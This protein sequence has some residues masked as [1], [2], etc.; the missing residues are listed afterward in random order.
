[1]KRSHDAIDE[2]PAASNGV[3]QPRAA[4]NS[5]A[6]QAQLS[7]AAAERDA[8]LRQ[9]LLLESN[10]PLA[11]APLL[12]APLDAAVALHNAQSGVDDATAARL[13]PTLLRRA[14]QAL[15]GNVFMLLAFAVF[16]LIGFG[17]HAVS[18]QTLL[19]VF[20]LF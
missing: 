11:A 12:A 16:S 4:T 13:P 19:C 17:F 8:A 20:M 18:K 6:L 14:P 1:M 5:D 9:L 3:K 7:S 10:R 2:Q 15:L